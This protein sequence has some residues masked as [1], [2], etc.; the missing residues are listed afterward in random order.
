MSTS[1]SPADG[2]HIVP[3][4]RSGAEI[5]IRYGTGRPLT[6]GPATALAGYLSAISS[7]SEGEGV[8]RHS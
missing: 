4:V 5:G 6:G 3:Q 8:T 2:W 1:E 7:G